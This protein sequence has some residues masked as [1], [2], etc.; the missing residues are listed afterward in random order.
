MH[1]DS[2]A[3]PACRLRP[4]MSRIQ[5]GLSGHKLCAELEQKLALPGEVAYADKNGDI[6]DMPFRWM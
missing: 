3:R 5:N 6:T 2:A 1:G 4:G